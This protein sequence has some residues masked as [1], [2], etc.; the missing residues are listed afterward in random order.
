MSPAA[1]R[2]VRFDDLSSLLFL[3]ALAANTACIATTGSVALRLV[4]LLPQAL[5][6][7]GCQ[8]AKHLA[9]HG[10]FLSDRR[11]N[12]AV[13][14]VCAALFGMNFE[15][16]RHFHL[17][18]HR[19]VC[20]EHDPEG[21][22]YAMS[23]RTRAIWLLA[24]FELPWVAYHLQRLA[25]PM[26]PPGRRPALVSGAAVQLAMA[27][28]VAALAWRHPLAVLWALALPLALACWI[29]FPLTQGEHYGVAVLPASHRRDAGE[30]ANDIVLP[31][32]LG[33]LTLHRS[34]HRVHHRQPG[35]PWV[36]A[37]R[38]LRAGPVPM[39]YAGFVR[40]WWA[41]GPR[42]WPPASPASPGAQ[43]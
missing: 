18:H 9:V 23:W 13:G 14:T 32:G 6:L 43:A 41:G 31:L 12:D 16:F 27:G 40:R 8:E 33:W 22:L 2:L 19:A 38:S 10:R 26:V 11:L 5:L 3:L 37:P 24:P 1:N 30:L 25:W 20:T 21:A 36:E 4:L 17:R 34:L 15:A 39:S 35:R 29:D 7:L 42:L 28:L